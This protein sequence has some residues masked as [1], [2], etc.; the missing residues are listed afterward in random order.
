ME[1]GKSRGDGGQRQ[2]LLVDPA[3]GGNERGQVGLL[4]ILDLIEEQKDASV[5]RSGDPP[6]LDEEIAEI[7]IELARVGD[8]LQWLYAEAVLDGARVMDGRAESERAKGSEG[9]SSHVCDLLVPP[10]VE[11]GAT[12]H[13]GHHCSEWLGTVLRPLHLS[14]S[15][16]PR[17]ILREALES[18]EEHRLADASEPRDQ[19]APLVSPG[20]HA[21]HEKLDLVDLRFASGKLRW[22]R[23][24]ARCEWVSKWVHP[25]SR[26]VAWQVV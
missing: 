19:Q 20:L 17:A 15:D 23:A 26:C 11:Q 5:L 9:T 12:A 14:K 6:E 13:L 8:A 21:A 22:R 3:E 7:K 10:E 2:V 1:L 18:V 16:A 24:C 4:E 25:S